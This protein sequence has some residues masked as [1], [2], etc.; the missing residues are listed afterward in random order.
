VK[1]LSNYGLCCIEY[2]VKT[3]TLSEKTVKFLV[4]FFSIKYPFFGYISL[5][6][7]NPLKSEFGK[8]GTLATYSKMKIPILN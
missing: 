5:A 4:K 2:F 8:F 7:K 1:K 3:D 6:G